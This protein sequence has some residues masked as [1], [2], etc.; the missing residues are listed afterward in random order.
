MDPGEVLIL[1]HRRKPLVQPLIRA[2]Q[3]KGVPV[4]GMVVFEYSVLVE[5]VAIG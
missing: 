5:P 4:A 1:V 2:L 3:R